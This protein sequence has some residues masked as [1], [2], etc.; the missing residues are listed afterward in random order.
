[1]QDVLAHKYLVGSTYHLVLSVLKEH[2]NVI[3]IGAVAH[4][5]VLLEAGSDESFLS[6]DVEFLVCL[7]H[8]RSLDG[9]EAAYLGA[10]RM[11]LAILVAYVFKPVYGYIGHVGE[12]VLYVGKFCLDACN[13]FVG[14]VLV[15][16]QY[17]LHLDFEQ[18]QNVIACDFAMERVFH[19]L[20]LHY[21]FSRILG[22]RHP[23]Y[24]V[25][26][27]FEL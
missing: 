19:H 8:L 3:N 23:E 22:R 20:L 11:V 10:A 14:L 12:V 25:F 15:V 27:R 9:V 13:E 26:E 5:L 18:S 4:K 7:N 6:V 1:M 16:L 2:Y 24:L 21:A 17:A